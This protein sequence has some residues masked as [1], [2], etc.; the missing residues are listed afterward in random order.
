M[1]YLLIR[2]LIIFD[3]EEIYSADFKLFPHIELL[4]TSVGH[5]FTFKG[6]SIAILILE[7]RE[8]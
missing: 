1:N 3:F 5:N 2:I 4:Q 6:N 7:R 8:I